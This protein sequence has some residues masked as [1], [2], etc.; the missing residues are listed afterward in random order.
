[1]PD[2]ERIKSIV[3]HHFY[4]DPNTGDIFRAVDS[5][6]VAAGT[7][8]GHPMIS[9]YIGVALP[10]IRVKVYGHHIVYFLV[11]G[12]WG[13]QELIQ[14]DHK[15]CNRSNNQFDNLREATPSMNSCNRLLVHGASAYTTKNGK[16]YR[17]QLKVG[18][19][20]YEKAGFLTPEESKSWYENEK[21][22]RS[23]ELF[24]E[25]IGAQVR[26]SA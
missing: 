8:V 17:S 13:P 16:R 11:T 20:K 5:N 22:I 18:G 1:M 3:K 25:P 7:R 24:G 23:T 15:D 12:R 14:I 6:R 10:E 2:Y 26:V 21:R 4:C 19:V 9:G